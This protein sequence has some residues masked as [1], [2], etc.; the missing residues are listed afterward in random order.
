MRCFDMNILPYNKLMAP[1]KTYTKILG[2]K[3]KK[4]ADYAKVVTMNSDLRND[5]QLIIDDDDTLLSFLVKDVL[6][7]AHRVAE[8]PKI[9]P[10]TIEEVT[11]LLQ[12]QE[13][14]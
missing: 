4:G 2:A 8:R 13:A 5:L 14:Q 7:E 9:N 1:F 12:E 3:S 6:V 10:E 11:A